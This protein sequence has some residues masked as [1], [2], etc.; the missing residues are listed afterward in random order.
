MLRP[1]EEYA[2]LEAAEYL[3]MAGVVLP[4]TALFAFVDVIVEQRV[5]FRSESDG[6]LL[7]RVLALCPFVDDP[8]AGIAKIREVLGKQALGGYRLRDL[9][10]A[11]GES[12]SD[13]AVELV[14][15]LAAD[16][17]A[18]REC[19]DEITWGLARLDTR[20]SRDI[21]LGF[22]DPDITM[23]LT[24]PVGRE[25]LLVARLV[26]LAKRRPEVAARLRELCRRELPE[27]K[28]HLLSKVLSRFG[29]REDVLA[30]L[31]LVNDDR[32]TQIPAGVWEQH[33]RVFVERRRDGEEPDVYTLHAR[34]SNE[35]RARLLEMAHRD[36]KRRKSASKLLG[37]IE[38]WR[39]E[40]GRPTNEPRHPD[41]A[42]GHPWPPR[43]I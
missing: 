6:A 37:Q 38:V 19:E 2:Q 14:Y 28:R 15:E 35:L 34:A 8:A 9:F 30:N 33:H 10:A 26:D 25:D 42:S 36:R 20:R 31:A 17:Y 11:L 3:L 41:L 5:P 43:E 21:L 1:W 27:R 24:G 4:A 23:A 40:Y 39:L 32:P 16:E 29:S 18:F 7:S 12:R 13:A 22:V